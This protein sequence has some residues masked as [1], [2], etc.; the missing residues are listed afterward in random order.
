MLFNPSSWLSAL[1]LNDVFNYAQSPAGSPTVSQAV[2]GIP[3]TKSNAT[4]QRDAF[5]DTLV[6]NMT[7]P[8][9][10]ELPRNI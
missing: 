4:L 9:L 7:I 5:L 10:G 3:E 2:L 6:A 1:Q 8:E